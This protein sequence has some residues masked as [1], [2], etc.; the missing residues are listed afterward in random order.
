MPSLTLE[1]DLI[2]EKIRTE[3]ARQEKLGLESRLLRLKI[4][5]LESS[6]K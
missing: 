1:N 2:R 5:K 4:E 6:K 3:Q